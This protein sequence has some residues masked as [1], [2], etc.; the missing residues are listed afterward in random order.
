VRCGEGIAGGP[1]GP[2]FFVHGA[3]GFIR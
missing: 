2:P 3:A 1:G